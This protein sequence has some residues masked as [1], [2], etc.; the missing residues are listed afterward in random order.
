MLWETTTGGQSWAAISPDLTPSHVGGPAERRR[1][2]RAA[3]AKPTQRG[4]IYTI[5]PSYVDEQTIWAGTD[6]GLIHVTRDGGKHLERRDAAGPDAVVKV[7]L[8]DASHFDASTAY[9]AINTF[10]LDDLRPHIYRT[11]DGGKTWTHITNGI[12]DG[13][14]INIVREDPKRRG[15]LFAGSEQ[16]VYVSFDNGEHWQSLRLNMP[17]TSIRDLVIKDDDLVA[18]THG[19]AFWILD[20]ITP[21]R[22]LPDT[23][24]SAG[25]QLFAP[26]E[27]TRVRWNMNTDTPLPPD[28]PAGQNPPDGALLQLLAGR[29]CASP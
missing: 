19:R 1:L 13:G 10:R 5:A 20:D 28:E 17:A 6:D 8:M 29:G 15:L 11:H 24:L 21:L 22:Q 7:S 9:A 4:V 25:P 16:A 12:P 26:Q 23:P 3:E 18:G 27:A 2:R 14:I